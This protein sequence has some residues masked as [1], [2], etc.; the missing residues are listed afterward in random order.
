MRWHDARHFHSRTQPA[1][2]AAGREVA[3]KHRPAPREVETWRYAEALGR[4]LDLM[5]LYGASPD[6]L[7]GSGRCGDGGALAGDDRIPRHR[8]RRLAAPCEE[9]GLADRVRQR[10]TL[11]TR[12]ADAWETQPP[13][14]PIVAAGIANADPVAARLLGVVAR[15][16]QGAVV[17][18]GLDTDM[19][20][21]EWDA[22]GAFDPHPQ[23]PLKLLLDDM[24]VARGEVEEWP[25]IRNA[26]GRRAHP[27]RGRSAVP[28]CAY[29]AVGE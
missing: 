11:L 3:A 7:V 20:Q 19:P 22:L 25:A 17:L 18:P 8:A 9:A 10:Q 6:G 4:A 29:R 28:T 26:T 21:E 27:C 15:L 1:L 13:Q 16:P 14:A 5:Q 2:D 12:T 23:V 24:S